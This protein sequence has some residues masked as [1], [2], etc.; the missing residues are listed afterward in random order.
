[1]GIQAFLEIKKYK[2]TLHQRREQ[3]S[4]WLESIYNLLRSVVGV[5]SKM[6]FLFF[7]RKNILTNPSSSCPV[8]YFRQAPQKYSTP[9]SEDAIWTEKMVTFFPLPLSLE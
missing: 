5:K 2:I 1:M 4:L 6:I 9:D 7:K 3:S 8:I